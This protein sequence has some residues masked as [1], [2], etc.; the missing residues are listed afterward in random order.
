[1][2]DAQQKQ[3]QGNVDAKS[4]LLG[5]NRGQN[6]SVLTR[7][8]NATRVYMLTTTITGEYPRSRAKCLAVL[9]KVVV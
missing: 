7:Q 4:V 9:K 8:M 3:K 5:L 2:S 1:M 6:P